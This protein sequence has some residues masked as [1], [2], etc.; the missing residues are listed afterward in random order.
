M[1][2]KTESIERIAILNRG[3][4]AVRFLRALREYNAERRTQIAAVACWTDADANAPWIRLA[5][6][7]VALGPAQCSDGA[8]GLV[9]A[10]CDHKRVIAALVAA[11]CDAVWPGWGFV[12]EDPRFVELANAAGLQFI[13]PSAAAM[14]LL[15]DK[16]AAKELAEACAVPLG[17]WTTVGENM[18]EA[19]LLAAGDTIGYPL[20][21]KASAGGGGRGIRRVTGPEELLAAVAA[22]MEEVRKVFGQGGLLLEACV[23]GARH[24]EVQFVV[25]SNGKASAIGTRD[26]SIQR[27]NQKVIEEGPSPVLSAKAETSVQDATVRLTEA[28]G[29]IGVGTAEFLYQADSDSLCFLEVNSRLQ[30]EHTITEATTGCDL[31]H[32]QLDIARKIPWPAP[33]GP[34]HGHAI[35]VRLNA[36]SPEHDFR[37]SP[38]MIRL[39][40][41]P[42]GPGIRVDCGVTEGQAIP[43]DFDS[44]IAKVIAWA[45]TRAKAI[46][47]LTRAVNELQVV[48][49]DGATNKAFLLELLRHPAFVDGSA[50]TRW[51]DRAVT[52]GDF[53]TPAG[54]FE[55]LLVAAVVEYRLQRRAHIERFFAQ[56]QDGIPQQVPPPEALQIGLRLRDR[57]CTL[58]VHA[59]GQDR[60]LVGTEGQLHRIVVE[61]VGPHAVVL[62]LDGRRHNS[63]YARGRAGIGVEI[64][65]AMH[66]VERASGGVLAAPAPAMVVHVAVAEGDRVAAGDRV[67]TLEA[68]K[69]EMPVFAPEAGVIRSLLCRANE[70]VAVGQPLAFIEPESDDR[71]AAKAPTALPAPRQTALDRV[72]QSDEPVTALRGLGASAHVQAIAALVEEVAAIVLGYDMPATRIAAIEALLDD[73]ALLE[74]VVDVDSLRPLVRLLGA[75]ADAGSLFDRNLLPVAGEG[76]AASAE[77][78][79][80]EFCRRHHEGAEGADDTLRPLLERTMLWYGVRGLQANDQL[81]AALWRLASG[82]L[83]GAARHRV[84]S[85]LLRLAMALHESGVDLQQE[86]GLAEVITCVAQVA[87]PE[88][89]FVSD[90]ATEANYVLFE[91]QRWVR[92]RHELDAA[93]G[94]VLA[95]LATLDPGS[96]RAQTRV[97]ELVESRQPVLATVL[98]RTDPRATEA[99]RVAEVALRRL[100]AGTVCAGLRFE[101]RQDTARVDAAMVLADGSTP[102]NLIV[103]GGAAVAA[104]AAVRDLLQER[105]VTSRRIVELAWTGTEPPPL[106]ELDAAVQGLVDDAQPQKRLARLT[107]SWPN[108]GRALRHR[109]WLPTAAGMAV[110]ERLGDLH[111]ETAW[112][113]ELWRL[114]EFDLTRLD[115]PEH[116]VAYRGRARSNPKDERVFVFAELRDVPDNLDDP[117]AATRLWEFERAYFEGIRIIRQVQAGTNQRDRFHWNRLTFY[118]RPLLAL[119][120]D[121][122]ARIAHGL[123]A[124]ARGAGLQKVVV[125]A[126]V[127]DPRSPSGRRPVE[128]IIAMPGSHRLDV[129]VRTPPAL[130][131]RAMTPYDMCVVRSRRLGAIY[132]YEIVRL[133]EGQLAPERLPHADMADGAFVEYDLD[134]ANALMPVQR[135]R[136]QNTCGVVIGLVSHRTARCPDGMERV[137]IASDPTFAMGALAEPECRRVVAAIELASA[138]DLVVEWLPV[139]SGARIAMD[140]GTENLD[141]TARVLRQIIEFTQQ[142][143]VIHVIV[144]GINV[145]AQSYWN[146]EATM[147]MHCAGLLIMTPD[148]AMVLTGKKAL[149]YSGSVA[150]EDERG[151]G[152]FSRIMGPN[153]QGQIFAADIGAAYAILFEH[154]RNAWVAPGE[155]SPRR[156]VTD[157][158]ADRSILAAPYVG[159]EGFA[160]VGEIFSDATNPGRKRPFAIR[161]VMAAAVDVDCQPVER[162]GVMAEADTAVVW[163]ARMGGMPVCVV[164][165]ESRSLPRRGRIPMDGPETWSGGTLFPQSSRKVARALNAASGRRPVVVLANLS[166]FDGS[167][168]S[169]RRLQL[170]YGAEIGRAVVNFEGPIVFVVIGRYHGGAY[171]VFSKALNEGLHAMAME[172]TYA[173]VIGGAPAAAVVFPRLVR[174]RT[175]QRPEV[176]AARKAL[177]EASPNR[178]AKLREALDACVAE[179]LLEVQGEV[180]REFDAVH[181]VERAV[182]VGSLDKVIAPADLR[183]AVIGVLQ[184]ADAQL[185]M[186]S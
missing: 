6:D 2:N 120:A 170:E 38:G 133:L 122:I 29:Y 178:R 109:T 167:P 168:E 165:I 77:L 157:D 108:G 45:P 4:P 16:I 184:D 87:R 57:S 92:Q 42:A 83:H 55:A 180:A 70:Q 161:Q 105:P 14:R 137:W 117:D 148:G 145:G 172:G 111:P 34:S 171:V 80:Y 63:L 40:R 86:A 64:D 134:E 66:A 149:E 131:V 43:P 123:E 52:A 18:S 36:E 112:R 100:Y 35:E 15:G 95:D 97:D 62:Q 49:E 186:A 98:R 126:Q 12:S 179:V 136:G 125:R 177:A 169:L 68:M 22:A 1:A 164:G 44:M 175:M 74:A 147:L 166:G 50:D 96:E 146:A 51:L 33:A 21:A 11:G 185:R 141:W 75:F 159:S 140:S 78:A 47:R 54:S 155:N 176:L 85:L 60:Y 46:A 151:I 17:P 67:C 61:A 119:G 27:R 28:A 93:I 130:P 90:N 138:R 91:Q 102:V 59:L 48:V 88:F 174:Q 84:V 152:G 82:N 135:P 13:G 116:L 132:P 144:A 99:P 173:S 39:L 101:A 154:Y 106:A 58:D 160:T 71:A 53:D 143:G 89:P 124:P 72:L 9:S 26:C 7:A 37:P 73:E 31:I 103:C 41:L 25:D 65:G 32:A 94:A 30:V 107:V 3:E 20:M 139:S 118:V 129:Q 110:D 162:F 183:P 79:F 182:E 142:G 104:L 69:M 23:E 81:R 10:Y 150:A 19:D 121:H 113:I 76:A 153:G 128:L 56:A 181:T 163:D 115:A 114:Q 127:A 158:P 8:G 156:H 5:D 24:I